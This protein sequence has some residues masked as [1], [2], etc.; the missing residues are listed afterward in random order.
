MRPTRDETMMV[1]AE[2]FGKR[3]TCDRLHVGAVIS[4]NGRVIST[5]YNGAPAGIPHCYHPHG[6]LKGGCTQAVHAEANAIAFAARYGVSVEEA[7]LHTTHQPCLNCAMLIVNAGVSRVVFWLPYRL[8][9]G[10]NLLHSAGIT[11]MK[12]S[13]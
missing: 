8:N 13:R 12:L 10:L 4:R 5:G 11:T 3:S 2:T 7:E 1:V 9:D 6:E